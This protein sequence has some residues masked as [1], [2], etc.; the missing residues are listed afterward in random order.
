MK[1]RDFIALAA[2]A[3][4]SAAALAQ[5]TYPS[6]PITIVVP[7]PPGGATDVLARALAEEMGKR[8]GQPVVVDNKPGAAGVLAAQYITRAAPDGHTLLLTNSSPLLNAPYLT[9]VPYDPRRDFTLLSQ[10]CTGPLVLAVNSSIVPAKSMKEFVAWAA[11]MKGKVSYGSYGAGTTGHLMSAYLNDSRKLDMVH[12]AYKGE[13]PL[14]QDLAGGQIA[15]GIATAGSVAAHAASGRVR[16][17]AVM[18]DRPVADLPAVPTMADAGF[19]ETEF[20][21]VGWIG[22]VGPANMP[23]PVLERLERELPAAAQTPQMKSRFQAFGLEPVGNTPA[24]FRRDY[25]ISAPVSERMVK[26]SGVR[27]D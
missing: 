22:M 20:K 8:M 10:L 11:A 12:V 24:E 3:C 4:C 16:V 14:L 21:T 17:L 2:T 23:A 25:E 13:A 26:A 6:R 9:K 1:R 18:G 27:I 15:W 19:P 5:A 7:G